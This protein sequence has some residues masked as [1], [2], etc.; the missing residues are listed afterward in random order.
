M[1]NHPYTESTL[2]VTKEG[3]VTMA[4]P[5]DYAGTIGSDISSHL[6]TERSVR[7][8]I[9]LVSEVFPLAEGYAGVAQSHPILRMEGDMGFVST[10]YPRCLHRLVT[11][12][13]RGTPYDI[14]VT[15]T[16][17]MVIYDTT[18]GRS[19]ETLL[20]PGIPVSRAQEVFSRIAAEPSGSLDT[21]SGTGTGSDRD[22]R[23]GMGHRRHRHRGVARRRHEGYRYGVAASVKR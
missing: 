17:G 12:L 21:R 8:Q 15:Q 5:E 14:W 10:A 18:P 13:M 9:P 7:E 4:V 3:I 22:Q 19:G 20:R 23:S 6:E 16:D 2:V 11:L 1:L